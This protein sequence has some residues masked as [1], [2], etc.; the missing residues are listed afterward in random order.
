M[1]QIISKYSGL[2]MLFKEL[3]NVT[4]LPIVLILPILQLKLQIN[5]SIHLI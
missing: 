5:N 1:G 2:K 4:I 3:P